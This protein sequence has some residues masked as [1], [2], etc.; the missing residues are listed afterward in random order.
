MSIKEQVGRIASTLV[1][2]LHTRL[3][4]ASVELEEELLRFS[5]YFIVA[6]IALFCAG[7]AVSLLIF[8]VIALYWDQHRIAVLLSL[9]GAF[10]LA[11]AAISVWLRN[12]FLNRP[13]LFENSFAELRKDV[14]LIHVKTQQQEMEQMVEQEQPAEQQS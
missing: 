13:R 12:Q 3:E 7:V 1:D 6:L 4:L 2:M 11:S 10:G 14:D 8:L 5:T 9:I